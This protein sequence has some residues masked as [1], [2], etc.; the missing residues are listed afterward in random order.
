[1]QA[2]APKDIMFRNL[3]NYTEV[4]AGLLGYWTDNSEDKLMIYGPLNVPTLNV[5]MSSRDDENALNR[6]ISTAEGFFLPRVMDYTIWTFGGQRT[7]ESKGYTQM[8]RL[9]GMRKLGPA[10]E[11]PVSGLEIDIVRDRD[12]LMDF[13][14]VAFEA[15]EFPN[16]TKDV[17]FEAFKKAPLSILKKAELLVGY[18]DGEAVSNAIS[19]SNEESNGIYFVGTAQKARGMGIGSAITARCVNL[20][21]AKGIGTSLLQ[22]SEEGYGVYKK[23]G[24][25]TV[26][27]LELY[28]K[29]K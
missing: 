24:F 1:M 5:A 23:A 21:I 29:S 3:V 4:L 13:A 12:G 19:F 22:S 25:E 10:V 18:L 27:Y 16:E 28:L 20:G 9:P 14:K 15:N 26:C 6:L 2:D 7:I 11:M 8:A 17:Y